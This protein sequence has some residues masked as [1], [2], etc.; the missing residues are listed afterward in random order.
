[1]TKETFE[2]LAVVFGEKEWGFKVTKKDS[3]DEQYIVM[4]S[5]EQSHKLVEAMALTK[6]IF[7]RDCP[8]ERLNAI[9]K[10]ITYGV[11]AYNVP[12]DVVEEIVK[13]FC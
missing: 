12:A 5:L 3:L 1:M 6:C 8:I 7:S 9:S 11:S 2:K 13:G 10:L 4:K